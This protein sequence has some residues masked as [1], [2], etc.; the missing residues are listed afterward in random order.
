MFAYFL[1]TGYGIDRSHNAPDYLITNGS[2]S[3]AVEATT[4]NP[5]ESEALK[6]WVEKKEEAKTESDFL[7]I[8]MNEYPIRFGSPLYSKLRK[9]Y[10]EKEH[11]RDKPLVI[12]LQAFWDD[13]SLRNSGIA[14]ATYLYGLNHTSSRDSQGHL[15]IQSDSVKEH[16]VDEKSI[17]SSFFTQ[18]DT[19]HI[20]AVIYSNTGTSG[21]MTRMGYQHGYGSNRFRVIRKGFSYNPNPEAADESLFEYD[22]DDPPSTETWGEGCIVFH[23]PNCLCPI[24]DD[25][26]GNIVQCRLVNGENEFV[27]PDRHPFAS[28]TIVFDLHDFKKNIPGITP[29]VCVNA[30]SREEFV[31]LSGWEEG[32]DKRFY[33]EEAWFA[34]Q[35]LGFLGVLVHYKI[36]DDWGYIILARNR[37]Y[38][39]S[40]IYAQCALAN[41]HLARYLLQQKVSELLKSSQRLF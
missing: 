2:I 26:F 6:R 20:S 37:H 30:I 35:S 15:V 32:V 24:P 39:F 22:L 14:L 3:V 34:D 29:Q 13:S 25:F 41:R 12:A 7:E 18:E 40:N 9:R 4:V 27:Y 5:S 36:D 17:P 8:L 28:Q 16:T 10:W 11:C 33:E 31:S 38:I 21:K 23:N 19:E 1:R